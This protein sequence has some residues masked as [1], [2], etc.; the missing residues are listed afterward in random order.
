MSPATWFFTGTRCFLPKRA[1][2]IPNGVRFTAFDGG[3]AVLA[4]RTFFSVGG[5]FIAEDGID[6]KAAAD[7]KFVFP[8]RF[9]A[10][11]NCLKQPRRTPSRSIA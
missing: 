9:I 4:E 3:G 2:G 7:P 5:G 8:T 11:R 10:G 1:R 6:E